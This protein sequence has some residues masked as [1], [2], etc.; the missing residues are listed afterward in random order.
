MKLNT[1]IIKDYVSFPIIISFLNSSPLDCR[2][3]RVTVY[4]QDKVRQSSDLTLI[5]LDE[6]TALRNSEQEEAYICFGYDESIEF[7]K[8]MDIIFVTP[9]FNP[10]EI[11]EN[12]QDTFN[13]FSNWEKKLL[14]L[15]N[16]NAP[17]K[18]LGECTL[19]FIN[20]PIAVYTS[21]LRNIFFCERK[22]D[23]NLMLY[24]EEDTNK[25]LPPEEI[26]ELKFNQEFISTI[27]ATEP[28][29]FSAEMWGYRILFHNIRIYDIYIARIVISETERPFKVSDL[30][31]LKFLSSILEIAILKQDL[32]T[33][34]HPQDFETVVN[35][36]LDKESVDES[37]LKRILQY[38]NWNIDDCYF[39][40][41]IEIS[42]YDQVIHTVSTIGSILEANIPG[43][44]A[45]QQKDYIF[46]IANLNVG[47]KT[48]ESLLSVLVYIL[49]EGL[50]KAGV[51]EEF[52]NFK[53]LGEYYL[54][55]CDAI[56]IGSIYDETV[57][58]YRYEQYAL[59][60]LILRAAAESNVEALCPQGLLRLIKYDEKHKREYA[61]TLKIY[62]QNNL[63]VVKTIRHLYMQR[64]TFL[65]QLKRILEISALNLDN[66]KVKLHL[67]IVFEIMEE[68]KLILSGK[69][70][71]FEI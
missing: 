25:Y 34:D 14:K 48:R 65:Y 51:S 18:E 62:L 49:R 27:D 40:V 56:R 26:D 46:L 4:R 50:L 12:L 2:L 35:Q 41:A 21:G 58:C 67:L 29:L 42:S 17:L 31:L 3:E 9:E 32:P 1:H 68:R 8:N 5:K 22:K 64:A 23:K 7:P 20:N 44:V 36:I 69:E 47:G 24:S 19:P 55:A 16:K 13:L 33:N 57:W 70:H 37:K 6:L 63:S 66:P 71:P 45:L 54:Q 60:R 39:C 53:N 10:L 38:E 43:S 11:M 52:N 61:K 15:L 30:P 28:T 59:K